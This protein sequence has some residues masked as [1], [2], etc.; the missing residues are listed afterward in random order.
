[1]VF[2]NVT[3]PVMFSMT[4]LIVKTLKKKNKK[5]KPV[6]LRISLY[7]FSFSQLISVS[8][9]VFFFSFPHCICDGVKFSTF[10]V[11]EHLV[12]NTSKKLYSY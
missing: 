1:M 3:P 7:D 11:F 2:L 4:K 5:K 9:S 8:T 10:E 6:I 12:L